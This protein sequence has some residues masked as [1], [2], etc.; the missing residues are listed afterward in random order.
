VTRA[1]RARALHWLLGIAVFAVALGVWEL[2][3]RAEQNFLF[4]QMTTVAEE[5]W[6]LWPSDAFV[7]EV[8]SSLERLGVGYLVGAGLA[9]VLGTA[10][11]ASA[12]AGRALEPTIE[13]LRATPP[14][15]LIPILVVIVGFTDTMRVSVIAFGV[16]FPVFVHTVDGLRSLP[17]EMRDTARSMQL[18]G[19]RTTLRVG[20]PNAMPRIWVGLRVALA[21]GVIMV[22]ISELVGA[23]NGIGYFIAYN[24][25][26][27]NVPA[28]YAGILFLGL[29]GYALNA[30]FLACERYVLA[31]HYGAQA[32][33]TP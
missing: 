26:Q 22:V 21:I 15:A 7:H 10:A 30:L 28:V 8:R 25:Q 3:A 31:W 24:Q 4:P 20:V 5:A 29:L 2:A 6:R 17:P 18:G 27:F 9:V 33:T 1:R 14:I 32:E 13:F 11:G 19:I 16:F 12:L 23:E